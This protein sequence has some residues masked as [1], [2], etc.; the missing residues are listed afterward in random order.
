MRL[1]VTGSGGQLGKELLHC[2]RTASLQTDVALSDYAEAGIDAADSGMLDISD[3]AAVDAWFEEHRPYDIVFNCAAYTNVDRCE[4]NPNRAYAVN[5]NGPLNLARA[6]TRTGAVLVHVS[7]DYVFPGNNPIPRVEE[8]ATAPISVYGLSKLDGENAVRAEAKRHHIV[9]TAWLYGVG[10]HNFVE[11]M[12]QLGDEHSSISVVDDQFGNPTNASDLALSMLR[13]ALTDLYG[14]WHCT[15]NGTCS[16]ADFAGE[17]MRLSG[18]MCAI[19]PVTSDQYKATAP[20]S[21]DRPLYSSLDNRR[22]RKTIGDTMRPWHTA[23]ASYLDNTN[24]LAIRD[25]KRQL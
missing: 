20:E 14:I 18:T 4:T 19:N 3:C 6:C 25:E 21:A 17:I 23:L 16:W 7:T 9:R 12:L 8:D 1:L 24:R 15:N 10:G 11:T 2:V 22:L 5:A 13:I